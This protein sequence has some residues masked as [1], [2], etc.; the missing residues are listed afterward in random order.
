MLAHRQHV[1][2]SKQSSQRTGMR[3]MLAS[4]AH[5]MSILE[6]RCSNADRHREHHGQLRHGCQCLQ[7][8]IAAL[9]L[10]V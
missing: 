10:K 1:P 2:V 4:V 8:A 7:A 5:H 3:C 6:L 9:Q